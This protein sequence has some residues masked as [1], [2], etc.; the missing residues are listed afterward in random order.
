L[1]FAYLLPYFIFCGKINPVKRG[2]SF[3]DLRCKDNVCF[4]QKKF[5]NFAAFSRRRTL[6]V[7]AKQSASAASEIPLVIKNRNMN[8]KDFELREWQ[9]SDAASLAENADNPA[10]VLP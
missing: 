6:A 9:M 3:H 1:L 10:K 2:L 8:T 7:R 5:S 4:E